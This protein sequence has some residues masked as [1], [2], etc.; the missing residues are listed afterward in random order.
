MQPLALEAITVDEIDLSL[1][2]E[3]NISLAVLRLDKIHSMISGNKWFK[4]K[5]YLQDAKA[6]AKKRVA[7]FGGAFS[8]HVLA[9]AAAGKLYGFETTG[10][11]RGERP[12]VLSHTLR[13]ATDQGMELIFI[14]RE[15]YRKKE[16]PHEIKASNEFFVINEGGYGGQGV[17]GSGAF[18]HLA[19]V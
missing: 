4:L 3:K 16:L 9:V 17:E 6:L 11:I 14:D 7:T 10:I 8:N 1:A 13:Q 12:I 2:R 19:V 5:Y 15:K 18:A